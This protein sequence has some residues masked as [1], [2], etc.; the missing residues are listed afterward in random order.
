MIYKIRTYLIRLLAGNMEIAI[1]I[2]IDTGTVI[3]T[4]PSYI[5]NL[6]YSNIPYTGLIVKGQSVDESK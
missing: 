4:G 2:H 1:N 3:L 5:R 6:R